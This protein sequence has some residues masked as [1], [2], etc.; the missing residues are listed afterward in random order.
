MGGKAKFKDY[1]T[2]PNYPNSS[3]IYFNYANVWHIFY[4]YFDIKLN[5]ISPV[6]KNKNFSYYFKFLEYK[7][8]N[9][10]TYSQFYAVL[11]AYAFNLAYYNLYLKYEEGSPCTYSAIYWLFNFLKDYISIYLV[12]NPLFLYYPINK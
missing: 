6:Q 10:T 11:S 2:I 1:K 4:L 7:S 8:W 5:I 12:N 9:L 3:S